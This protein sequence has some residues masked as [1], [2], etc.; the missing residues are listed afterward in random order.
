MEHIS[1][2]ETVFKRLQEKGLKLQKSKIQFMLSEV[3]YNGFTIS[4]NGVKPTVQKVEAIHAAEA[5]TNINELR[6]FIGFANY[7]R[8]FVPK[9]AEIVSPLYQL[10]KKESKWRW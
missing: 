1:N 7:L 8:N 6:S 2:L 4:K 9:F 5:P 3:E 10:L